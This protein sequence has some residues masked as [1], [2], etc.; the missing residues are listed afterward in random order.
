MNLRTA[1]RTLGQSLSGRDNALNFVRLCLA[2]LVIVAHAHIGGFEIPAVIGN[3][4]A[5]AVAGFF[6]IS[7]FLIAG[8]RVRGRLSGF[9]WRRALR[10]FPAFWVCLLVVAFVFA[11]IVSA[12]VGDPYSLPSALSYVV[13]NSLLWIWQPEI[14]GTLTTAPYGGTW[15]GSLWTL[16]YE[17][18][19]YL[20]AAVLFTFGM[21]KRNSTPVLGVLLAAS[22]ILD[23]VAAEQLGVTTKVYLN[24]IRLGSYFLAGMFVWS[25]R[26]KLPVSHALGF[27][28]LFMVAAF[29]LATEETVPFSFAALPLAYLVLWLGAALPTRIGA[30]NDY[31]YGI[32][33]YGAPIQ[34]SLSV[35]GVSGVTGL[36][37]SILITLFLATAIAAASWHLVEKPALKYARILD[38]APEKFRS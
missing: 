2:A 20:G 32:Y 31:S 12:I 34:Q 29:Y 3:L 27:V 9:I 15:N 28:S 21:I 7:G 22:L 14:E 19:A 10:I 5:V 23:L 38:G 1:N 4:G 25:L 35:T 16:F 33:I 36:V 24:M 11:P 6:A 13:N 17:F 26:D 18:C 8:S 30:T 37:G